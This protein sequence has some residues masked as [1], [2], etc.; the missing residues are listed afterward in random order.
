MTGDSCG[1]RDNSGRRDTRHSGHRDNSLRADIRGGCHSDRYS[2]CDRNY[3]RYSGLDHSRWQ[4][5]PC[6]MRS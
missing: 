1:R 3:S 2:R 5:A 6:Q 4:P